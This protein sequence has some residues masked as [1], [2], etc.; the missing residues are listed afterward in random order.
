MITELQRASPFDQAASSFTTKRHIVSFSGTMISEKAPEQE[1]D[2]GQETLQDIADRIVGDL[3]KQGLTFRDT[4]AVI[5]MMQDLLE[6][7]RRMHRLKLD[8]TPIKEL[9]MARTKQE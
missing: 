3:I 7:I 9:M 5:E 4:F 1:E 8:T 2:A 6:Y